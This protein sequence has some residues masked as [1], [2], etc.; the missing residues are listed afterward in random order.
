M[1]DPSG[2]GRIIEL[3]C[4]KQGSLVFSL[5]IAPPLTS[6]ASLLQLNELFSRETEFNVFGNP[7]LAG[8]LPTS[9]LPSNWIASI[10]KPFLH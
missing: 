2:L 5:H 9:L 7:S 3:S 1:F 10:K 6:T 8:M 4:K